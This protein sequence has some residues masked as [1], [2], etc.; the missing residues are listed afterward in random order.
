M[1]KLLL[2]LFVAILSAV[3]L[4]SAEANIEVGKAA[5]NFQGIDTQGNTINLSDYKGKIVVL[6]W[7]NHQCPYVV[8][9][10][11]GGNMQSLQKETT[12]EGVVW[13]TI[14]S[15]AEGKQGYTKPQEANAIIEAKD[16]HATARILDPSGKIGHLYGARTTPHMFV[17]DAQGT[18]AYAGAI[19]SNSSV[20]SST[21]A[22]ATNYVREAVNDL[23]AGK[24][25]K[26]SSTKPYG[27]SVKY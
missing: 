11:E 23:M 8:K 5:P 9:H 15:S 2:G 7:S 27:C 16:A 12:K 13:L 14:V 19:D 18:L 10:Y 25:V 24:D 22:S 21:I 6:E 1:R 26:I 17:V 20:K 4:L 3:P